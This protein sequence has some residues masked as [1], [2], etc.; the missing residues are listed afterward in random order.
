MI[1]IS[2]AAAQEA[3]AITSEQQALVKEW[4]S[5]CRDKN[6][7]ARS[8]YVDYDRGVNI[9]RWGWKERAFKFTVKSAV[10]LEILTSAKTLNAALKL[11]A[12]LSNE[13]ESWVAR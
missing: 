4:L 9:G 5:F 8:V 12:K 2:T 10:T 3:E 11:A 1:I 7:R 13:R 6:V